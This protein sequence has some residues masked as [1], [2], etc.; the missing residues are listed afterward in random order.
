MFVIAF[1]GMVHHEKSLNVSQ[2]IEKLDSLF[3]WTVLAT[4]LGA[5][6]GHVF[7]YDWEYFAIT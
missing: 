6:L 5:R 2:S 1:G 7:F 3:V 4:L